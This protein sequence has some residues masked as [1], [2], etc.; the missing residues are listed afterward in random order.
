[1][2]VSWQNNNF[3]WL[4][5]WPVHTGIVKS[6]GQKQVQKGGVLSVEG[7]RA[8][9]KAREDTEAEKVAKQVEK[10]LKRREKELNK[11][12]REGFMTQHLDSI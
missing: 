3:M 9:V 12:Q 11:E 6:G 2:F 8:A 5:L 4:L 1:M 10:E 7:A